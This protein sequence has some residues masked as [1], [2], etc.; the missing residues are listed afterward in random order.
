MVLY[1]DDVDNRYLIKYTPIINYPSNYKF[2][3]V[4]QHLHFALSDYLLGKDNIAMYFQSQLHLQVQDKAYLQDLFHETNY[5]KY[6]HQYLSD[7][8]SHFHPHQEY[9]E[10]I[11]E[12]VPV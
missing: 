8:L 11:L 9:I 4:L 12:M 10:Y 7:M 1:H 5:Y 6:C 3:L 2:L